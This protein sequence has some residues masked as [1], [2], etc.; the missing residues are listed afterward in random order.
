MNVKWYLIVMLICISL[1]SDVEHPLMCLFKSFA[2]FMLYK[3]NI[4]I[5]LNFYCSKIHII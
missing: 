2:H 4:F 5:F 3:T 1:F